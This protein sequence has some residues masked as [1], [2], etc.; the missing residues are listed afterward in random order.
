M[1]QHLDYVVDCDSHVMEP[2]DLWERYIEPRFRDRAIRIATDADGLETLLIDNQPLLK[3]VLAGLG[4]ANL[5]RQPLFVPGKVR[6]AEGCPPASYLPE[7]RVRL[8]ERM[9]RRCGRAVSDRWNSVGCPGKRSRVRL[10][11][12]L[13]RL[14]Q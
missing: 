6:Y 2:P 4:G 3:G 12:R 13:Q 9:G 8:L 7:E 5:S 14:D 10:C 11:T 1:D